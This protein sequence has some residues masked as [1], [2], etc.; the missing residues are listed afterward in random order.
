MCE[1]PDTVS[2]STLALK[3]RSWKLEL[4]C[5]LEALQQEGLP[6]AQRNTTGPSLGR[7]TRTFEVSYPA[8]A[9]DEDGGSLFKARL[10][11]GVWLSAEEVQGRGKERRGNCSQLHGLGSK[12]YLR[13]KHQLFPSGEE[14]RDRDYLPSAPGRLRGLGAEVPAQEVTPQRY[15][16]E[17]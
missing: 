14:G 10:Q 3:Y 13:R 8:H 7:Y 4:G 15:I 2:S 5:L 1:P 12:S 16:R 17:Q 9:E 6:L 11:F